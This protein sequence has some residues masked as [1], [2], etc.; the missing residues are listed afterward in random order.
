[1]RKPLK[2]KLTD[3]QEHALYAVAFAGR[4]TSGMI[5]VDRAALQNL[6]VDHGRALDALPDGFDTGSGTQSPMRQHV[7]KLGEA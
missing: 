3:D 6:L 5:R 2:L 4:K 7:R 1:M